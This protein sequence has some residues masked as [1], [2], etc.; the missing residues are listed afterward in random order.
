M[1]RVEALFAERDSELQV[2]EN[3]ALAQQRSAS[4]PAGA[5]RAARDPRRQCGHSVVM[6][7]DTSVVPLGPAAV[8]LD[9]VIVFAVA[10]PLVVGMGVD[11]SSVWGQGRAAPSIAL[12]GMLDLL[13]VGDPLAGPMPGWWCIPLQSM[14]TLPRRLL[15]DGPGRQRAAGDRQ[16]PSGP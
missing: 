9:A 10:L 5:N 14:P 16:G 3:L 11:L 7:L 8:A 12:A 4:S 6:D 13:L 1:V 2:L 15:Q